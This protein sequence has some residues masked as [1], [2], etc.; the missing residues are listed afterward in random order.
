MNSVVSADGG[1]VAPP[2]PEAGKEPR[3][4]A[5]MQLWSHMAEGGFDRRR[6]M[7][8]DNPDMSD[9]VCIA[10][11]GLIGGSLGMALRRRG[12]RVSYVDPSVTLEAA[13]AAGA[14]D[15]RLEAP[16]GPLTVLATPVDVA[17][18]Q[19]DALN[20]MDAVVTTT[21]SVMS[22]FAGEP[23]VAGHP[24]AGSERS[25]LAAATPDLFVGRPWF[26]ARHDPGVE[27]MV[28]DAGA[29]PVVID[30]VE[31]D[32][33][34][35]LTSHLPQLVST[36]LG[37]ML[38]EIDPSFI[39]SGAASMLRLAGSS[40]DVWRPVLEANRVNLDEGIETFIQSLRA[41]S[42]DEFRRANETYA[43]LKGE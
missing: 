26:L 34:M 22:P 24:F 15:Q 7:R 33:I 8:C 3:A 12:W 40:Y 38:G 4:W 43:R 31:H 27:R 39:G 41:V 11:L 35:A 25:G 14:V 2:R 1:A 16:E 23:V 18:A 6:T 32:R 17:V 37:S 29:M 42:E 13:R 9:V 5:T 20:G 30:P 19:L 28:S 21:C 10:G 36:A